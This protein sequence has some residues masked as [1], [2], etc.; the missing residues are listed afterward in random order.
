MIPNNQ[1]WFNNGGEN[2]PSIPLG[3]VFAETFSPQTGSY[4]NV[5]SA[6]SL[7]TAGNMAVGG[8]NGTPSNQ[9]VLNNIIWN[10]N[11]FYHKVTYSH[12]N[13]NLG[14]FTLYQG[15]T[16]TVTNSNF[17]NAYWG[18]Y[19]FDLANSSK[20]QISAWNATTGYVDVV[21]SAT[22]LTM[23]P[24]QDISL[25]TT[26]VE[27]VLT[28]VAINTITLQS[29]SLSYTFALSYPQSNF[30]PNTGKYMM[31]APVSTCNVKSINIGT[32]YLVGVKRL[33]EGDSLT[34]GLFAGSS[35]NT[36]PN[37]YAAETGKTVCVFAGIADKSSNMLQHLAQSLLLLPEKVHILI[38]TN[39]ILHGV[40]PATVIA[41]IQTAITA[42]QGIGASVFVG[43]LLPLNGQNQL[44]MNALINAL[45]GVTI[46]DYYSAFDDPGNP[47]N[48]KPALNAGDGVHIP[49]AGE[50][51]MKN[52]QI[53]AGF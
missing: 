24:S 53:A 49:L 48:L 7:V 36:H 39:D 14:Q 18:F 3:D 17:Y 26:I 6:T 11:N 37:L 44:P 20:L 28:I 38:G 2:A 40:A 25:I 10:I 34:A 42:Y 15:I 33:Y 52:M 45:T 35:A 22:G 13:T 27:N 4:T 50:I 1:F 21:T 41:N 19:Y 23:N 30:K 16:S 46:I 9:V 29:I 8:G 51:I 5:G 43:T 12:T 31:F 47:G 32:N